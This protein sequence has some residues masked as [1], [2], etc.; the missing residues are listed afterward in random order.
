MTIKA[1]RE[2]YSR[3]DV[4]TMTVGELISALENYNHNDKVYLSFDGGYTYG[5]ITESNMKEE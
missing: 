3:R 2:C 1:E 5:G 4:C